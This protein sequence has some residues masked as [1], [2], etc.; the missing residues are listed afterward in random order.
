MSG[1]RGKADVATL[2]LRRALQKLDWKS[3]RFCCAVAR[4]RPDA[5]G[6]DNRPQSMRSRLVI[7]LVGALLLAACGTH[8]PSSKP[9]VGQ[10][11]QGSPEPPGG[12]SPPPASNPKPPEPPKGSGCPADKAQSQDLAHSAANLLD[13]GRE[14]EAKAELVKALCMD[15]SNALAESLMRQ[16]T[17]D[18]VAYFAEKYGGKSSKYTV[19]AGDTLSKIAA[20]YLGD[21]YQFY[22]LARYNGISVPKSVHAQQV[23]KVP[24]TASPTLPSPPVSPAS[25]PTTPPSPQAERLYQAGQQALIVGEKDKAYDLFMQ[26][27]KLDPKDPRARAEADKLKPELIALHERKAREAYARQDLDAAITE[28]GRVLDLDPNNTTALRERQRAI[29]L[30]KITKDLPDKATK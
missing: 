11:P 28:W 29:D 30:Q 14:A 2:R 1:G 13:E 21:P 8:P 16:I 5:S 17:A 4:L 23:I 7:S 19:K 25:Q 10:P 22:I 15:R 9:E 26:S 12:T 24:G 18:P 20:A 6:Q 3:R 27:A